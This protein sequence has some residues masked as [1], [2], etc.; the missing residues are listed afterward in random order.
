[1]DAN[2]FLLVLGQNCTY[3]TNNTLGRGQEPRAPMMNGGGGFDRRISDAKVRILKEKCLEN[4]ENLAR[5]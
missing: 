5:V 1:M 4:L 2:F 3:K